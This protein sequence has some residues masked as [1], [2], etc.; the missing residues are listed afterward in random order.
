MNTT[1]ISHA[2]A[3]RPA[4]SD[5]FILVAV[6]WI[7]GALSVLASVYAIY[8]TNTV[9]A[10]STYDDH[11]KTEALV[12]AAVELTAYRQQTTNSKSRPAHGQFDFRLGQANVKVTFR[13]EAAR[14]DLNKAPKQVLAGLFVVLGASPEAAATYGDRIISWRT[15]IS[16]D[17]NSEASAYRMAH[18]E[19]E[20]RGAPFPHVNELTLVRDLPKSVVE[21]ALP[22][23]TVYGGRPEINFLDAAPE[24]IAA[25]PGMAGERLNTFL[26][27]RKTSPANTQLLRSL[28][29]EAQAYT[30]DEAGKTFRISV[31]VVFDNRHKESA[32][33]VILLLEGSDKPFAV[34]SW[35]DGFDQTIV[36]SKL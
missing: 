33:V 11:L 17:Q 25:L 12:S 3:G 36:G 9:S 21:R 30:T 8:V 7:L 4:K 23:F 1:K 15:S 19:Y 26:E 18:F 5:G 32:E 10:F 14:I 16:Q 29:R 35:I 27:Q 22:F 24:V 31:E 34:L 13:S 28:L 6:L 2:V 20:S